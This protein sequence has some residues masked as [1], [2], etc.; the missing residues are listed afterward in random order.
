F[1]RGLT[2]AGLT[3]TAAQSVLGAVTSACFAQG[4]GWTPYTTQGNATAPVPYLPHN[5]AAPPPARAPAAIAGVKPFQGTGGPA[6][7]RQRVAG[8]GKWVS[9]I[10]ASEAAQLYEWWVDRP[11]LKSVPTPHEGRGAAK[12][13]GYMKAAG[14]PAVVMQAGVVGMMNAMGQIF[15]AWKE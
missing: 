7:A 1:V 10:W 14:E 11:Q 2:K 12:A 5:A 15:N 3:A 6:F 13:G 4:A 9:A 8:G